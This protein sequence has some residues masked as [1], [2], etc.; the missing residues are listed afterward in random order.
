M[1]EKAARIAKIR[2][3]QTLHGAIFATG[4]LDELNNVQKMHIVRFV[5]HDGAREEA[6]AG[7]GAVDLGHK[8]LEDIQL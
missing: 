6:Q 5:R 8:V 3:W 7:E 1:Q 2:E 4:E